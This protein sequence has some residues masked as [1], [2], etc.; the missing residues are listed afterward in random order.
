MHTFCYFSL[1]APE[2]HGH[3]QVVNVSCDLKFE[4]IESTTS[5]ADPV[6]TGGQIPKTTR[7]RDGFEWII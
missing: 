4:Q 2:A 5:H 3:F 7:L 6:L 1:I